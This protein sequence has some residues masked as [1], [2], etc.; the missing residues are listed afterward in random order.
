MNY[1]NSLFLYLIIGQSVLFAQTDS[2][3]KSFKP[4][5]LIDAAPIAISKDDFK[6]PINLA[7][8]T[9]D[10]ITKLPVDAKIN[11]YVFGDSVISTKN[12]KAVSFAA[13]GNEKIVVISN[14][15]GYIWNAKI[16]KTTLTDMSCIL[17]LKRIRKGDEIVIKNVDLSSKNNISESAFYADLYG[18]QEFLK[19]NLGIKIQ[20]SGCPKEREE[21]FFQMIKDSNRKRF[22]FKN[23]RKPKQVNNATITIKII[24]I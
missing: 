4:Y 1:L 17:E 7:I 18:L 5:G 20:I 16:F 24:D 10:E 15:Q 13:N 19:L 11:T 22:S 23:G 14:A 6:P 21:V 9:V 3:K 8:Q 2:T 12:G